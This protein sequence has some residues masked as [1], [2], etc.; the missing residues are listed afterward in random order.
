MTTRSLTRRLLGYRPQR[1]T[2]PLWLNG[3]ILGK[4]P[5]VFAPYAQATRT[6]VALMTW[7][8]M[9]ALGMAE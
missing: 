3:I 2:R 7:R 4:T 6:H 5:G 8:F 9:K 1:V